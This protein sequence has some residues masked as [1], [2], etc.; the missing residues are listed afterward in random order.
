MS[1]DLVLT[2]GAPVPDVVE[3]SGGSSGTVVLTAPSSSAELDLAGGTAPTDV[4]ASAGVLPGALQ[5]GVIGIPGQTGATGPAG[6]TGPVGP[7]GPTGPTGP[8]GIPGA[9][10]ATGPQGPAGP[11]NLFIQQGPAPSMPTE[12][13]FVE[14]N[15]DGSVKT[16][17]VGTNP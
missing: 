9:T 16:M 13:L 10:G 15:N 1:G 3:S 8:Q 12:G 17:W 14:L 6:P 7:T 5:V 4:A 11:Q 2:P